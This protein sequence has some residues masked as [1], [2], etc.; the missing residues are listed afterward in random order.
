[1]SSI[2]AAGVSVNEQATPTDIRLKIPI[3]VQLCSGLK[4]FFSYPVP[5]ELRK[6]EESRF[7]L[8][9]GAEPRHGL[10]LGRVLATGLWSTALKEQETAGVTDLLASWSTPPS[11]L[12]VAGAG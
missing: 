12:T 10:A 11:S 4:A 9:L 7:S 5:S 8:V 1:M 3:C 6:V 2:L